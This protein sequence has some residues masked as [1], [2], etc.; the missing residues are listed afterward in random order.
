MTEDE[1]L[2]KY[3]ID[4]ETLQEMYD[5]WRT[6]VPKSDIER[7]YLGKP[8]SHG[9]LFTNL[10]RRHL[11]RETER[12][13]KMQAERDQLLDRVDWLE[14]ENRRLREMLRKQDSE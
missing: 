6:G 3:G 7:R 14:S 5:E 1:D 10:V 8:E 11:G 12:K 4:L 9:K 2:A 13:S